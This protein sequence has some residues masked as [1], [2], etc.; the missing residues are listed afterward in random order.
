[1]KI[2]RPDP[3]K[4]EPKKRGR[5]PNA[6]RPIPGRI[7]KTK[8]NKQKKYIKIKRFAKEY[9]IDLN[10][11]KAYRRCGY[12]TGDNG[13]DIANANDLLDRPDV[14]QLLIDLEEERN[15]RVEIT[16]DMVVR[17]L[18]LLAS[19]NIRDIANWDGNSFV[20]KPFNE[21]TR[22]QT[23]II[24]ALKVMP[25]QFGGLDL[26]F[27]VP[28]ASDQRQ[29]WVDLGKHMGMFWEGEKQGDPVEVAKKIRQALAQM[30]ERTASKK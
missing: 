15:K 22:D 20:L 11:A 10:A 16:Q 7:Y 28:S 18:F 23:Y 8:A 24:S 1:M 29:C 4:P 27:K 3:P 21:L 17:G 19:A 14:R 25:K 5:P 13:L 12:G 2:N 9:L 6:T 30:E 26:D